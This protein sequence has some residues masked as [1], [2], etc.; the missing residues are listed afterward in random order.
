MTAAVEP[1]GEFKQIA[2]WRHL[3]VVVA[4]MIAVAVQGLMFQAQ[5]NQAR[6]PRG[7]MVYLSLILMEL[8]LIYL[9]WRGVKSTG[10]TLRDLISG[11]WESA[12]DVLRDI[13]LAFVLWLTLIGIA[14]TWRAFAG[15]S[16]LPTSVTAMLPQTPIEIIM[17]IGLSISAGAAE[18]IVFRGYLQRQFAALTGSS[19]IALAAQAL[20]FGVSHGY[21]GIDAMLRI[22]LLAVAF[23]LMALWRKSLRPGI[24]AHAWTD[25]ASGV[26]HA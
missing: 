25:I 9:V 20:L 13:A 7:A 8:A 24:I 12:A 1:K 19:W 5:S 2:S 6:L 26:F 10:T 17:W 18:E 21:Q 11:R 22:T 3:A 15:G 14:L 4:I 23:G 16:G